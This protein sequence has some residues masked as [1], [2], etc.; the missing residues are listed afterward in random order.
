M[1]GNGAAKTEGANVVLVV[2]GLLT[3]AACLQTL[4]AECPGSCRGQGS[5]HWRKEMA[6]CIQRVGPKGSF[7][8]P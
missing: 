6:V 5:T 3:I 2:Q 1:T 4:G 7:P 8:Q